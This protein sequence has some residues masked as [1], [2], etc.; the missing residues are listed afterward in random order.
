MF[1]DVYIHSTKTKGLSTKSQDDRGEQV[2]DWQEDVALPEC[3]FEKPSQN[4]LMT[5]VKGH[6][7]HFL[8]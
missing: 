1:M 8:R 2:S 6:E 3:Y 7:L 4:L 5:L